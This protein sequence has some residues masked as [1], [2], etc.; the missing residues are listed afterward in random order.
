M[1]EAVEQV[2]VRQLPDGR[3]DRE[4][5]ALYLG[6]TPKTLAMWALCGRGPKPVKA[7]GRIFYYRADLDR[8]IKHGE[9]A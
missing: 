1:T 4:N 9:T 8:F 7:G 5:A 3:L 2:R 6:C